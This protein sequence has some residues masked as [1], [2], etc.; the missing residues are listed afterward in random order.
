MPQASSTLHVKDSF[1]L[2]TVAMATLLLLLVA[3]SMYRLTS[4]AYPLGY[5]WIDLARHT[6]GKTK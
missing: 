3:I 1:L 4:Y 5:T 6:V 2:L